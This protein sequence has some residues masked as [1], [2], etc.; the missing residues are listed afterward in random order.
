MKIRMYKSICAIALI[1]FVSC[2]KDKKEPE[3]VEEITTEQVE[4]KST[5]TKVDLNKTDQITASGFKDDQTAKIFEQYLL[6]KK[7][8]V[9]TDAKGVQQAAKGFDPIIGDEE[10]LKALKANAKLIALTKDIKKQ[11]DFF[12]TLTDETEKLVASGIVSGQVYKQ[13]C[14]MAFNDQGGYWLSNSKEVRN[15]YFGD[16]MLKCGMVK[17]TL[18]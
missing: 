14:P 4:E 11:R 7:A 8:L 13:F 17:V 2:K 12:V 10:A 5:K 15:P 18:E 16:K 1:T 3:I 6:V 9:N